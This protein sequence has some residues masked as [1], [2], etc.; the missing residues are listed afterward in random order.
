MIK[1]SHAWLPRLFFYRYFER[2]LRNHF[3]HFYRVNNV[4]NIDKATSLIITPNHFSWWDGFIVLAVARLY[5]PKTFYLMMLEEQLSRYR[6]F[7]KL[8]AFSIDPGHISRVREALRYSIDILRS[9]DNLIVFYP[10]G[11]LESYD[12]RPLTLQKGIY[13]LI[14][15]T[16][17][18]A[19]ILIVGFKINFY[20][21][22]LPEIIVRFG[23]YFGCSELENYPER[24]GQAFLKNIERLDQ[25]SYERD[26]DEDIFYGSSRLL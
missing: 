3:S 22:K 15:R 17:S 18:I 21:E 10:Q 12:R 9:P 7:R 19:S 25:A 8:G 1:A 20:E 5:I 24:F 13:S 23:E 16:A 14:R 26:F 4:P 6:Y 2:L 11:K